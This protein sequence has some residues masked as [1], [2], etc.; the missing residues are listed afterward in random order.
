MLKLS[1]KAVE[2]FYIMTSGYKKD[3]LYTSLRSKCETCS[4]EGQLASR[5]SIYEFN[6][7]GWDFNCSD[8]GRITV[9]HHTAL[10][11]LLEISPMSLISEQNKSVS[12]GKEDY[13][14]KIN[15]Q[16]KV[17]QDSWQCSKLY[18]IQLRGTGFSFSK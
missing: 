14:Y 11:V 4:L 15:R 1:N 7:P 17:C 3:F 8:L 9:I 5:N 18:K 6:I 12:Q 10:Q 2:M 16:I 13:L